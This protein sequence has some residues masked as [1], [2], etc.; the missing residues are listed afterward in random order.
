MATL[1]LFAFWRTVRLRR[2][3]W[4]AVTPGGDP[5]DYAGTG[6]EQAARVALSGTCVVLWLAVAMAPRLVPGGAAAVPAETVVVL[7]LLGLLPLGS[8][9]AYRA[10]SA[11]LSRTRWRGIRFDRGGGALRYAALVC[12]EAAAVVLSL[13]YLWPR[14]RFALA[15]FRTDRS[16]FGDQG[17]RQGGDWRMLQPPFARVYL[18]AYA[19]AVALALSVF[20]WRPALWA[21]CLLLPLTAAGAISWR[22]AAQRLLLA[23]VS[24]GPLGFA[25]PAGSV[26]PVRPIVA[27][28]L[29]FS[30]LAAPVVAGLGLVVRGT[31]VPD[32]RH[33]RALVAAEPVLAGL[34]LGLVLAALV[35]WSALWQ[36]TV[37]LPLHR[38]LATRLVLT[39]TD[40]LAGVRQSGPSGPSGSSGPSAPS[41]TPTPRP[42]VAA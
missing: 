9:L 39:G 34:G 42:Q 3:L 15:A 8:A 13:G 29:L 22:V 10:G 19:S 7:F 11:R 12:R 26:P 24:A 14:M 17:L 33:A 4:S 35:L 16:S 41:G 31:A 21:L 18:P 27:A 5:L 25:V 23:R 1:G 36:A 30:L 38:H 2:Y 40:A 28:V 32:L 37:R 20:V 6:M